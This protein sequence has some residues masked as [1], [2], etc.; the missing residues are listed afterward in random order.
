MSVLII[1]PSAMLNAGAQ[2]PLSL[3][4]AAD[5]HYSPLSM[6]GPIGEENGLPGDPL[7]WYTNIQGEL[8]YESDAIMT[9]LLSRFEA[10]A[11]NFLLIA[12]DLSDNGLRG[13]HTALAD[14]FKQFE[15][16]TGKSIFIINGNHDVSSISDSNY[17]NLAEFKSIYA[18]FGY[19]EALASDKNS[20]S[21]TAELA[22][23]YRLLAIDSCI[24]GE[25][26]GQ[27]SADL[28]KWIKTQI[29]ATKADG[30]KLVGMMH[31]S[32]LA[33]FKIQ[34]IVG[35][36]V[37]DYRKLSA[38]FADSGIKVVFTGH[39]HANDITA[40]V[41]ANGNRIYDIETTSLVNYPNSY[42][43]ITFSDSAVKVETSNI[44]KLNIS[45]LA[46]GYNQ[47]QLDLIKTDFHAYSYGYFQAGM[48]RYINEYV[49]TPRKV[50]GW[51]KIEKDSAAYN[52][53]SLAMPVF[54]KALALPIYDKAGTPAID[55]VEEI[56]KSVGEKIAPSS[57]TRFSDLIAF[58]VTRLFS[59]DE[60]TPY[61]SPEVQLFLQTL[62]A[63]LVYAFVN[64]PNDAARELFKSLGLSGTGL[65]VND[66]SYTRAAKLIFAKTASEKIL[67]AVIKPLIEGI[68]VDAFAP[69]DLNVTLEAYGVS[70]GAT[71]SADP[72]T[73]FQ[74]I[75]DIIKSMFNLFV[76][77]MKAATVF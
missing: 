33:H 46:P 73:D 16:R 1:V 6:L 51:L 36:T 4:V 13:E 40:A 65:I 20:A 21:Y 29:A 62:K 25:D 31:H 70:G 34:G 45:E 10:S 38:L 47:A 15:K 7:Y 19:N 49:G 68:T 30:K 76:N 75:T 74:V 44:D 3:L 58:L 14:K 59:G 26:G 63:G 28:L 57:Y 77:V 9:E 54:G 72:I 52:A 39:K 71:A 66:A 27:I 50:A 2:A 18:D 48:C 56:A 32:L 55:S 23:G 24:Y 35:D 12:G 43:N 60:N 41:S 69:G 64:I 42:R 17:I 22:N 11:S 61:D 67:S 37:K 5:C 53:L 8:T